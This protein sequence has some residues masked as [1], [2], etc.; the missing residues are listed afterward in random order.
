MTAFKIPKK[1]AKQAEP[2]VTTGPAAAYQEYV[3]DRAMR[4]AMERARRDQPSLV[5]LSSKVLDVPV[6]QIR[7]K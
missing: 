2:V 5:S 7:S 1:A 3:P 4:A 6:Y